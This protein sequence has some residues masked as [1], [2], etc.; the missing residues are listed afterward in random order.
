MYYICYL[1]GWLAIA[2]LNSA[3]FDSTVHM[4]AAEWSR[5]MGRF[6]DVLDG[7]AFSPEGLARYYHIQVTC[8]LFIIVSILCAFS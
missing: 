7:D 3:D 5:R 6:F 2:S 8:A 4:P 1:V